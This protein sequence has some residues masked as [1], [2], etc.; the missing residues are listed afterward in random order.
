MFNVRIFHV[1]INQ[2]K[3]CDTLADLQTLHFTNYFEEFK[4]EYF[5]WR[6]Q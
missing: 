2:A 3:Y 1:T 6:Q 4:G 5:G